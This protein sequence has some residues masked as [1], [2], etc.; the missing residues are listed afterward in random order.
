MKNRN[1]ILLAGAI[2]VLVVASLLLFASTLLAKGKIQEIILPGGILLIVVMFMI[3]FIK[4]RILD[5]KKGYPYED[6][7]SK[8]IIT[9]ASARAFTLSI[10]WLLALMWYA[11]FAQESSWPELIPRHVAAAG[12][13]GMA[14]LFAL[15]YLY[16][17]WRG[18]VE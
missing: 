5:V 4:R 3:P 16:T 13:V 2:T 1:K 10:W 6:E 14:A 11:D 7:R 17:S 9:L 18:E 15:S 8:K 12:I